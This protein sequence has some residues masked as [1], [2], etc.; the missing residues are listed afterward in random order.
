LPATP[1]DAAKFAALS[2]HFA[3]QLQALWRAAL[4]A[5]QGALPE[6][7]TPADDRRFSA[8]EWHSMAYF[9]WLRQCYLLYGEYLRSLVASTALPPHEHQRLAF[10]AD[11]YLDAIAPSNFAA[12]NP[13]VLKR[14]LETEGASLMRG[15]A[16]LA[17]DVGR[18]RIS[19][20]APDA[21]EVGRNLAVT[22]GSVV[23]R[24]DLIEVLQYDATTPSVYKRPLVM[25]PPAINKY[26]ILDLTPRNSFVRHAVAQG[27]TVFMVSWRNI[28][29]QLGKLTFDDYIEDG[30]L[31]AIATARGI[32][33]S[34]SVNTLGF[35]VGGTL[36]A[37]ALAVLAA[38][39]DH[40]V[41]SATLLTTMLDFA[42]PGPIG[43]YLSP[44]FLASREATL[45]AGGRMHGGELASAFSSL[46][47]NDLVWNYVVSN[48]LK[49]QTPPAFDLL[50]W[51]SD[52][53]NLPG[54]MYA[55]YL[56]EMYLANRLRE[57]GALDIA[58]ASIDLG[59]ITVPAYVFAAR[60]DHIVPWRSAYAATSLLGGDVT[61]VLGASG[62]IAGVVNAPDAQR[63]NYWTNDLLT[64]DP[65][66]WLARATS[67]PGSWW[68]HWY[69]WLAHQSGAQHA[70]PKRTGSDQWPPLG[71]A[72][73]LQSRAKSG[74]AVTPSHPAPRLPAAY[75]SAA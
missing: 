36:L 37:S 20:V 62:H 24:N 71:A 46:R 38:R 25:I 10:M 48:Y 19:M 51:N 35:C 52:S 6:L 75:G 61:F 72:P 5:P 44:G 39:H 16:N 69:Q 55:Y 49:G 1:L 53:T 70:A 4:E 73:G 63:R 11:Q 13:E 32:T 17:G 14:S 22:P 26:Y 45:M 60:E 42:D 67:V 18:G 43:V 41:A 27:H 23:F 21:F 30:V 28:P 7:A 74:R 3:A 33:G 12:T 56:R 34:K 50:Y 47:A 64:D 68:P 40:S 58:G 54:P 9:S 31:A 8:P 29:E 57:P 2:T 65:E 66:A 59:R 15:L